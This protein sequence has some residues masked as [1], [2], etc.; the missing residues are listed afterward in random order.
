V[1]S[2]LFLPG[3]VL[4]TGHTGFKGTWMTLL[5]EALGTE[6]VGL[7]L[8]ATED[9][10]FNRLGRKGAIEEYTQDIRDFKELNNVISGV[11]PNFVIHLAAAALVKS[12]YDNPRETFSTNV[13]GTVNV[14]E[15]AQK[16]S[17]VSVVCVA[18]TD[19]VY[20]N[21][22]N[23]QSFVESDP[24]EGKDPYSASKVGTESAVAAWRNLSAISDGPKIIAVRAGNVIGGGDFAQDRIIPDLVRSRMNSVGCKIRN[25]LSTRPWQH[26]L[27]PVMGYLLAVNK[28]SRGAYDPGSLNFGPN[29]ESL[30]VQELV[31]VARNADKKIPTPVLEYSD[32]EQRESTFLN[33]NSE[34]ARQEL[35]WKNIWSQ[36]EAINAS[37][38]W[39]ASVLDGEA[40]PLNACQTEINHALSAYA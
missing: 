11:S 29:D 28:I 4:I 33:L 8:E 14:L 31:Q 7:S 21:L 2:S 6:V 23:N 22:E 27:D 18:T 40:K 39:W 24:L 36:E 17:D 1:S 35:G 15:A 25:P 13:M 9:S 26:V 10:L 20:R 3:K 37:I 32:K 38:I 30:S 19:K 34:K 12:S 5:L 16:H